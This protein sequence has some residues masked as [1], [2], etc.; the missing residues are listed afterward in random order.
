MASEKELFVTKQYVPVGQPISSNEHCIVYKVRCMAEKGT[1]DGILKMYR[2]QNI[3][4][5]YS[6]L[7]QLDYSEWPH[8]YNVKYFDESTLV[9]EEFLEGQTLAERMEQNRIRG[10]AFTE[11][12]ACRIMEKLCEAIDILLQVQPPIIHYNLKP[13]NI[14]ITKSGAVR[15][16]DFVPGTLKRQRPLHHMLDLLGRIFHEMLTGKPPKNRKCTYRGRFETIIS[17]CMEKNPEKQYN[18]M[19]E[20]QEDVE[21]AKTISQA[22][23]SPETAG[24]PYSLTIPFQGTI[25]AFEWILLSFFSAKNNLS[26]ACLFAVIF[27]IHCVCFAARRHAFLKEHGVSLSTARKAVP[28]LILAGVYI[29]LSLAVSFL[30]VPLT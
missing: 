20:L 21:H 12:E 7:Q 2:R 26:T 18:S 30:I 6:R 11:D 24:I 28:V 8:I 29:V 22:N 3:K 14:F 17:R 23:V 13:S 27:F 4:A 19:Q 15:L 16:L 5:L 25:M 1:P 10:V 9:V